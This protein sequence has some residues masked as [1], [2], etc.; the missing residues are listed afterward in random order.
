MPVRPETRSF[1]AVAHRALSVWICLVLCLLCPATRQALAQAAA[2]R[3]V[4]VLDAAHG[5]DDP[6]GHLSNGQPEKAFTLALSVR[7]RSLLTA[8][9]IQ[10]VTT[11]ESDT[12]VDLIAARRSLT[13]PMP[14]PASACTLPRPAPASIFSSLR[15]LRFSPSALPHGEPRRPPGSPAAWL[16]PGRLILRCSTQA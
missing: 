12:A 15:W 13:A 3:F 11:R 2:P 8:R 4:V 6:G 10:V 9:G 14:R 7:L 5:G 16:S 1:P